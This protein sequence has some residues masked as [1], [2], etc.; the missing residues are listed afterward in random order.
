MADNLSLD[1]ALITAE[2]FCAEDLN[3]YIAVIAGALKRCIKVDHYNFLFATPGGYDRHYSF[4]FPEEIFEDYKSRASSDLILQLAKQSE[5]GAC[6]HLDAIKDRLDAPPGWNALT[7][8]VEE[9][10]AVRDSIT[11][12]LSNEFSMDRG[13]GLTLWR[14]GSSPIFSATEVRL[15][16]QMAPV[17]AKAYG[18]LE[19][20]MLEPVERRMYNK[21]LQGSGQYAFLVNKDAKLL[22]PDDSLSVRLSELTG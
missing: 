3:G 8:A 17:L 1:L 14:V 9:K 5:P 16:K 20:A 2:L 7:A 4:S 13:A 6:I 15:L 10:I 19:T 21:V 22:K 12:V 18:K 11:I